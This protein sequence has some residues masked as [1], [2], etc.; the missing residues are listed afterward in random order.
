MKTKISPAVVGAFV[1]GAFALATLA[2]LSFGGFH[3]FEKPERFVV[4]FDES[5]SGLD[6][7]SAVKLRGVRVGRVTNLT[8]RYDGV[9][10]R[11]V[12][13]VVCE[14]NRDM[15]RDPT[16]AM[17]DV[18]SRAELERLVD[19]GLRAQ[20]GVAGLAT[21]LLFVELDF[22]DPKEYPAHVAAGNE[23][24]VVVPQ[25]PSAISEFQAA[26]GELLG[27]IKTVDFAGLTRDISTLAQTARKQIDGVDFKG[28]AEQWKKTG[29]QFETLASNPD[30][31]RTF[32]NL[33][34]LIA[35]M[36]VTVTKLD[37]QLVPLGKDVGA[38]L[39]ETRKTLEKFTATAAA[40]EAF[41]A[42]QGGVGPE[43]TRTL[44]QLNE[45]ADAVTRLV[46]FLERNPNALITGRKRPQ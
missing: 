3:F 30:F 39:A 26:I 32:D 37:A 46:D 7:G 34:Q 16:G 38:T 8:I 5:V 1:I 21:G 31:K 44:G 22:K 40:A 13:A 4:Y 43:L 20:L 9:K 14:L 45:A 36:R 23:R 29:A 28:L 41:I 12:V 10:N 6:Q 25:V 2:L 15:V 35:E 42:A 17:I 18:S 33:N 11:S 24:Y 19:R 27:K